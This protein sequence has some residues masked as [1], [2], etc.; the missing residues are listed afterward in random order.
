MPAVLATSAQRRS[1]AVVADRPFVFDQEVIGA[2]PIGSVVALLI[3]PTAR[4]H[5]L[6]SDYHTRRIDLERRI[7]NHVAQLTAMGY[8]VTLETAA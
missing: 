1:D 7:R 3:D 5:D 8:R 4:F 2:Q 6:G